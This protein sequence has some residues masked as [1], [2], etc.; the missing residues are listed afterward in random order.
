MIAKKTPNKLSRFS[1]RLVSSIK[2]K[3]I[4]D[5]ASY[6]KENN[7]GKICEFSKKVSCEERICACE[8]HV[9]W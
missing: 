4:Y 3:Y 2:G 5:I 7:S 9:F 6:F 8:F 1:D